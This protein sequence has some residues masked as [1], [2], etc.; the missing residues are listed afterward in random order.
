MPSHQALPG[1]VDLTRLLTLMLDGDAVAGERAMDALYDALRRVASRRMR[2]ERPGHLLET[3]ALI[4]EALVRL[5][6]ARHLTIRNRQ[7]FFA[8]VC[9]TMKRVLLDAGRRD[10]PAFACLDEAI[11]RH[12]RDEE[13]VVDLERMLTRLTDLDPQGSQVFRL[14]VGL[15]MTA[16]EAALEL[17]L[18]TATVNRAMRRARTWLQKELR[19]YL[20]TPAKGAGEPAEHAVDG[21]SRP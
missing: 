15:G 21:R 4:N 6:G 5:F 3:R 10:D 19:P 18:S 14:R 11:A 7:H 12:Q 8:L 20:D 2:S 13:R 9:L 17:D 1:P 16:D